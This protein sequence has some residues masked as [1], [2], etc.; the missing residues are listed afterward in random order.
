MSYW[1]TTLLLETTLGRNKPVYVLKP[2]FLSNACLIVF[3]NEAFLL[4]VDTIRERENAFNSFYVTEI[5]LKTLLILKN[6]IKKV[7]SFTELR[8]RTK[9]VRDQIS[10]A[11]I[12]VVSSSLT[13]SA[14]KNRTYKLFL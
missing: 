10:Q 7:L 3:L 5:F 14:I 13:L 12:V 6:V 9:H 4:V 8:H 11:L 2:K 1:R